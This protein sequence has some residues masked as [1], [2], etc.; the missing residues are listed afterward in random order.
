MQ[1]MWTRLYRLSSIKE[2]GTLYQLRNLIHRSSVL[3]S[4]KECMN[5]TEDFLQV[6][7]EGRLLAAS[8]QICG[9]ASVE[10]FLEKVPEQQTLAGLADA[11]VTSFIKPFF[12]SQTAHAG[13]QVH[14][15]SCDVLIL[16]LV[17]YS[18][19]DAVRE[20]DGPSVLLMWKVM[21]TAFR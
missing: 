2:K 15:Y 3:V 16:S 4:P 5:A 9:S 12:F 18:L 8:S 1:M 10:D 14:K 6:I 19:R 21:M 20:G 11:I 13:D 7:L 17:W